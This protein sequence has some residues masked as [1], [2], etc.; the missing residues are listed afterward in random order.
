ML[1]DLSSW[2]F[3]QSSLET[4]V[5]RPRATTNCGSNTV[6]T[7]GAGRQHLT[8]NDRVLPQQQLALC[9]PTTPLDAT[10]QLPHPGQDPPP[11]AG[12]S[13]VVNKVLQAPKGSD[14]SPASLAL[15]DAMTDAGI[16]SAGPSYRN[17]GSRTRRNDGAHNSSPEPTHA[18]T[19]ATTN[20]RQR[21]TNAPYRPHPAAGHRLRNALGQ[22]TIHACAVALV[23]TVGRQP[24]H[25]HLGRTPG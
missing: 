5:V 18:G 20:R 16:I 24:A 1:L 21:R 14:R 4:N 25:S 10:R 22:T 23:P 8:Q 6:T 11:N 3:N 2:A 12:L 9:R 7:A 13:R 19:Q 15:G 17:P